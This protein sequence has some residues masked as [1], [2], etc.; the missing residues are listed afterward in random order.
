[1]RVRVAERLDHGGTVGGGA[2]NVF[3][4]LAENG[5]AA[6]GPGVQDSHQLSQ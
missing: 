3:A 6:R 2:E 4:E 5:A 1:M